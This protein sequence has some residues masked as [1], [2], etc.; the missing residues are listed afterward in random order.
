MVGEIDFGALQTP[1]YFGNALRSQQLGQQAAAQTQRRNALAGYG[2]DPASSISQLASIDPEAAANL[3]RLHQADVGAQARATAAQQ[4]SGGNLAGA[5]ATALG[6]GDF[7]LLG[8]LGKMTDQQKAEAKDRADKIA[9][10]AYGLRQLPYDQ[11]KTR[12]AEIAPHAAQL[13]LK[14][15]D[16]ATVDPTD[17]V[18]DGYVSGALNLKDQI[19][20]H[21]KLSKPVELDPTKWVYQSDEAVGA[22]Q[23]S[24]GGPSAAPSSTSG[25]V[26]LE[27]FRNAIRQQESGNTAGAV[28][29]E[30]PYGQAEGV[31]QV[32]PTTA[33]PLAR[34]IGLPWNPSMMRGTTPAALA[35]QTKISNAAIDEALTASGGDPAK[36]A[37]YYFAGPNPQLHGPKTQAY[38]QSVM[39]K[40]QGA[41]QPYQVAATSDTPAPPTIPG[42]HLLHAPDQIQPEAALTDDAVQLLAG[43]YLKDGSLPPLG[44]GKAAA[45]ARQ[46]ILNQA[47]KMAKDL[48]LDAGDLVAGTLDIKATGHALDKSM[49]QLSTVKS[50]EETALKNADLMLTLAP[51]GGGQ[52]NIPALNR[53][54][55]AGRK[56]IA[57]DKDVTS[58]D[59]ALGTFADE[60]AKIV[61]GSTGSQ[62][63]T[64][65]SR[66]EAY[67]RL[68]KYATQGQLAAGIATM[69]QE[70]G[71]RISSME[72]VTDG[73][74]AHIRSG[75][76]S[77]GDQPVRVNSPDEAMRL[78][79]GTVFITPDG[80]RK[81]R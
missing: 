33:E 67:D 7:D 18:L 9:S 71:N 59:I 52:S 35:Y 43:R 37:A 29:P 12:L 2:S 72:D 50:F 15:E 80:R 34:R 55:Q 77:G 1:D 42:Y 8:A 74:R 57:G 28:G 21:D 30:T 11:R 48:G 49:T 6:A 39:A 27:A 16:I 25:G 31:G 68:S 73:L 70:M 3:S 17:G 5:Q 54:L 61:S 32:L 58:F 20:R 75:S 41:A 56:Q 4:F 46:K 45:G 66:R 24:S 36:A 78:A 62:G 19:E 44:M 13:G 76:S 10:L 14:P 26:D 64:D 38:V 22:P 51:K 69:K 23:A 40:M 65:A 81:I 47:T 60:Y 79:P 53:W 63:S